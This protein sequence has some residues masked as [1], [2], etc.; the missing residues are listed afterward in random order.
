[1]PELPDW[2]PDLYDVDVGL[3]HVA[4][5]PL[6]GPEIDFEEEIDRHF[7]L[8]G[9][10]FDVEEEGP[11]QLELPHLGTWRIE[12]AVYGAFGLSH[13]KLLFAGDYC[14][15]LALFPHRYH[16][17][18]YSNFRTADRHKVLTPEHFVYWDYHRFRERERV[19]GIYRDR[20]RESPSDAARHLDLGIMTLHF[21]LESA[22]D[23]LN[24]GLRLWPGTLDDAE[25]PLRKA[26]DLAPSCP[27]A[28]GVFGYF[29][30]TSARPREA[31][32]AYRRAAELDPSDPA[33]PASL[34]SVLEQLAIEDEAASA[35]HV[36]NR[37]FEARGHPGEPEPS[38]RYWPVHLEGAANRL[39]SS[40]EGVPNPPVEERVDE[41]R[42]RARIERTERV[43]SDLRDLIP[44]AERWGLGDDVSRGYLTERATEAEKEELAGVLADRWARIGDWI[45]G[46]PAGDLPHEAVVFMYMMEAAVEMGL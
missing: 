37:V 34:A 35:W 36:A 17:S 11:L 30:E 21:W 18:A 14:I 6:V 16:M 7:R 45:D 44:Y 31:A 2:Y 3:E 38:W 40:F 27:E 25:E 9:F 4:T 43:P 8:W 10:V 42:A 24:Q 39:R 22:P 20:I 15:V 12:D 46:Y 32:D 19:L 28:Y 5:P 29:L 1:M 33:Y 41:D 26:L 23:M 13:E